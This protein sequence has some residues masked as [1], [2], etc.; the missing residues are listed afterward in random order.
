VHIVAH[1]SIR[2]LKDLSDKTISIDVR[3]TGSAVVGTLLMER[4]GITATLIHEDSRLSLPRIR[5]GE[6][7]AHI[8]VLAKPT[9]LLSKLDNNGELHFLPVPF[10][11][12]L[13]DVYLPSTLTAEDYPNL[14]GA[15]ETVDTIAIGNVLATFN[16][17]SDTVRGA[18]VKRFVNAF[19]TRFEE[20][21]HEGFHP[22]WRDVNLAATMPGWTRLEAA[23]EWLD[24]HPVP[25]APVALEQAEPE[26]VPI[27]PLAAADAAPASDLMRQDAAASDPMQ[28]A[29][30]YVPMR[31]DAAAYDPIRQGAAASDPIRQDAP[32]SD[33][34]RQ[35]EEDLLRQ[36]FGKFLAERGIVPQQS[37][38]AQ[39]VNALFEEFKRW[40]STQ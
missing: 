31:L 25:I 30:A 9:E 3:G 27:P 32:A 12:K 7:A 11:E 38:D 4:L 14:I 2:S 37:A 33:L 17:P 15:N 6:I 29:A 1:T 19:F 39:A 35:D 8:F 13:A 16:W 10:D 22:R 24:A 36:Q 40:Q 28:G 18:K 23:Q 34:T 20:L 21:K 5:S 26:T